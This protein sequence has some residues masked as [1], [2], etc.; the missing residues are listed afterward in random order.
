M[1]QFWDDEKVHIL[2]M[3]GVISVVAIVGAV[4]KW[5]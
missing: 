2:V 3:A 4:V 1:K 5:L